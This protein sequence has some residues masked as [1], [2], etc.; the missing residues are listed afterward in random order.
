MTEK[1]RFEIAVIFLLASGLAC[2]SIVPDATAIS[3]ETSSQICFAP[4]ADF[5]FGPEDDKKM[6]TML[7]GQTLAISLGSNSSTGFEWTVQSFSPDLIQFVG[8]DYENWNPMPGSGGSTS[9]CFKAIAA[10]TSQLELYYR[11]P[12]EPASIPPIQTF[13]LTLSIQ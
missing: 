13:S 4:S 1:W 12:F 3:T 11:R 6:V 5:S 8:K 2:N 7:S 10:G 9:L